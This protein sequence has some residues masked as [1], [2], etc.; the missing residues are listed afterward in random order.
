MVKI[1]AQLIVEIA[2][3]PR[4]HVEEVMTKVVEKVKEEYEVIESFIQE[5][6]EVKEFWS[7]FVD[8]KMKFNS[9]EQLT[10]FCFEYMPSSVDI[11]EPVKFSLE[12]Y[13]LNN[14]FNDLMGKMHHYDLMLKNFRA[15]NEM[16]K[17]KLEKKD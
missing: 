8:I 3:F 14:L 12:S 5:P 16:L 10:G 17:R 15:T 6:R 9:M 4:E 13:E 1:T 2:G 11:I 7:S